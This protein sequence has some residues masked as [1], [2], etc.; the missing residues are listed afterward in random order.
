MTE[1]FDGLASNEKKP[2]KNPMGE[3]LNL[4]ETEIDPEKKRIKENLEGALVEL[5]NDKPY[6]VLFYLVQADILV[7]R[8]VVR[9]Y[10]QIC[11][12]IAAR[13]ILEGEKKDGT[14]GR[15]DSIGHANNVTYAYLNDYE[16]VKDDLSEKWQKVGD[17]LIWFLAA[18]KEGQ[19]MYNNN[20]E[21]VHG[22]SALYR[23]IGMEAEAEECNSKTN[24]LH[25]LSE[26]NANVALAVEAF[27][28]NVK[29]DDLISKEEAERIRV[30]AI[31]KVEEILKELEK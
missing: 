1:I 9:D 22:A 5:R 15:V 27:L 2:N 8:D 6:N 31:G 25:V 29:E 18:Q 10:Q 3:P 24:D 21:F 30:E 13:M 7:L 28:E 26:D 12:S 14:A 23:M 11:F 17:L 4:K 16:K 20:E 19:G